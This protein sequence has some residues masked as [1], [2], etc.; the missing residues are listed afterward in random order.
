GLEVRISLGHRHQATQRSAELL[1]GAGEPL[2]RGRIPGVG[3]RG[4]Q[5]FIGCV[6]RLD[7]CLERLAFV[8]YVS[9]RGLHQVRNQVV[10]ACELHVDLSE[11][12][13]EGVACRD[14][15]VV[16]GNEDNHG[17]D[18]DQQNYPDHET[19]DEE[20]TAPVRPL[21]ERSTPAS[22]RWRADLRDH[23]STLRAKLPGMPIMSMA[24]GAYRQPGTPAAAG[25]TP[26]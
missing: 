5:P 18:D 15:A 7:H 21:N 22:R 19:P 10:A 11:G 12:V 2:D 8:L 4:L 1:V 24:A 23:M 13:L 9:L 17:R 25:R 20:W 16:G 3:R 26:Y 6:A 14:Q